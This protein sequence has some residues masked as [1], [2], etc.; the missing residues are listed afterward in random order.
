MHITSWNISG[1]G[2]FQDLRHSGL[3]GGLVV[4]YGPNEAGKSTLLAFLLFVLFGKERGRRVHA[5]GGGRLG[6]RIELV[7]TDASMQGRT[8]TVERF[9]DDPPV[10][11]DAGRRLVGEEAVARLLGGT[12][13]KLFQSIY[14]FSLADLTSL[15]G[16][17]DG[18]TRERLF[19]GAVAGA[20]RSVD[21]AR[22]ILGREREKL[23]R[24]RADC[25]LRTTM[26]DL[27]A[28]DAQLA[29]ARREASQLVTLRRAIA[30][31]QVDR[32]RHETE[33]MQA[34]AR[35]HFATALTKAWPQVADALQA[36]AEIATLN[37]EAVLEPAHADQLR[38]HLDTVARGEQ[39]QTAAQEAL[40]GAE[41]RRDQIAVD[42]DVL[43]VAPRIRTLAAD[44]DAVRTDQETVERF[45]AGATLRQAELDA[46]LKR[47]GFKTLAQ[48]AAADL[49][50]ARVAALRLAAEGLREDERAQTAL[51][52]AQELADAEATALALKAAARD[53]MALDPVAERHALRVERL[54]TEQPEVLAD[55]A[56]LQDRRRAL[57]VAG[58]EL[59]AAQQA[60]APRPTA[61]TAP[62][63]AAQVIAVRAAAE[64]WRTAQSEA[65][66]ER[67]THAAQR[68][69]AQEAV[70]RAEQAHAA[71][72]VPTAVLEAAA[73]IQGLEV[74]SGHA[75]VAQA[76]ALEA[77]AA[78]A[79]AE[80]DAE[81]A[82][83]R[84]GPD[85]D[86]NRAG[87]V[88][89]GEPN[90][91]EGMRLAD[92][93]RRAD[94]RADVL[95]DQ[96][97]PID[98]NAL[99]PAAALAQLEAI[100]A[101]LAA[102]EA[103]DRAW[104]DRDARSA[105]AAGRGVPG[106]LPWVLLLGG[107]LL[108]LC[109]VF[110]AVGASSALG[111]LVVLF[112]VAYAAIGWYL[113]RFT[114]GRTGDG[115]QA[116]ADVARWAHAAAERLAAAG[117][118][119]DADPL[120]VTTARQQAEAAVRAG[121]RAAAAARTRR[122]WRE[123]DSAAQAAG[124]QYAAWCVRSGLSNE[125]APDDLAVHIAAVREACDALEKTGELRKKA[126]KNQA[127]AAAWTQERDALA[128]RLGL[129]PGS[130]ALAA[131]TGRLRA[132]EVAH[133]QGESR[134]A[135]LATATQVL[136]DL[137]RRGTRVEQ[138]A[139]KATE[140]EQ[141]LRQ[142]ART[143]G[144]PAAVPAAGVTGWLDALERAAMARAR[145]TALSEE[146][147]RLDRH[148]ERWRADLATVGAECGLTGSETAILDAARD[149][150]ATAR[151]AR[152][153]HDIAVFA[154]E[155]AQASVERAQRALGMARTDAA[156]SAA[157]P[158]LW[159]AARHA[160][161]L[162]DAVGPE[163]LDTALALTE[164]AQ[165]RAHESASGE[166]TCA[167]ARQRVHAW[168]QSAQDL[169]RDLDR[170]VPPN[171]SGAVE[172]VRKLDTALRDAEAARQRQAVADGEVAE[173]QAKLELVEARLQ[174]ARSTLDAALRA[175]GLTDPAAIRLAVERAAQASTC[176][177][178]VAL[179]E[180]GVRGLLGG[181]AEDPAVQARLATGDL[182]AWQAETASE[183]QAAATARTAR[184]TAS[185]DLGRL[186]G[187]LARLEAATDI[188]DKAAEQARL[189]ATQTADQVKLAVLSLAD[190]LLG[191][192][193]VRFRERHAPGV[194]RVASEH[195]RQATAGTY[196]RVEASADY[197][198][199]V[200]HDA[201]QGTRS[202]DDLS[203]GT[204]DLL[205]FTLRLGLAREQQPGGQTLPLVLDDILVNL[206]PERADGVCRVI[207]QEAA[208]RQ[209]LLLTCR[210]ET[211]ALVRAHVPEVAVVT[212][213]RFGGRRAP[214]T[215]PVRQERETRSTREAAEG[216]VDAAVMQVLRAGELLRRAEIVE[217]LGLDDATVTAALGRLRGNGAV[218]VEGQKR[219]TRYGVAG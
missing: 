164:V 193:L 73:A 52:R 213:D 27:L 108:L 68:V 4:V 67:S 28:V 128:T 18:A 126:A 182:A 191:Q 111:A 35:A 198:D 209:V 151:E 157:A 195:L 26:N 183:G 103:L 2:Q 114:R 112:A 79:Q 131:L 64:T 200:I 124:A 89:T 119:S 174:V 192:T 190:H 21:E 50:H 81:R 141:G 160:A 109:G 59:D 25:S 10:V 129:A 142:R 110:V 90:R 31:A 134:A 185:A 199:L 87:S 40:A 149:R 43:D 6:G 34:S 158:E 106:A 180:T 49:S 100:Q 48:L 23:W 76:T 82:L 135:E 125:T 154:W 62:V 203:R 161:G 88:Q 159:L 155:T 176:R 16:L 33:G 104:R 140:A 38:S 202:P 152:K 168:V 139:Q 204:K 41:V 189:R 11:V 69:A 96:I 166:A 55:R 19:A 206:D 170:T 115:A 45:T 12:D 44:L 147:D 20:G 57:Q 118:P 22:R 167:E 148:V 172:C 175:C 201:D 150:C 63:E 122:Q 121:E 196:A 197:S 98:A 30:Q 133:R 37:S 205:Y 215:P 169:G 99:S 217:R 39:E 171:A 29:V 14:A 136:G 72:A 211:V 137:E 78:A 80:R 8:V 47:S 71:V 188:P 144:V 84:L 143:V 178:R 207:A 54:T 46:A 77:E 1:F 13:R 194:F 186:Q 173:R 102:R 36:R 107:L 184:D 120:T 123:A 165:Q 177:E 138:A 181:A 97:E 156:H 61:D 162:H 58:L 113:L 53:A 179:A 214:V 24:T 163:A 210:P 86:A 65:T 146:V 3:P 105:A 15:D 7:L 93:L 85:W 218:R 9:D 117:L 116:D 219:G 75:L 17:G 95:H 94:Q 132:A 74:R 208:V 51:R 5:L 216:D 130:A 153:A 70:A 91:V 66:V 101:A 42:A 187:D 212:L 127:E 92:A 145:H 83:A 56:R 60:L 32:L